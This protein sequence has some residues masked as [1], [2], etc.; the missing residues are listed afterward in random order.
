MTAAPEGTRS[1][2]ELLAALEEEWLVSG[3]D[4]EELLEDLVWRR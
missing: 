3:V 1:Y 4:D 2:G